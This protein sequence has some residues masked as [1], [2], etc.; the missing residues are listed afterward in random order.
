MAEESLSRIKFA[1]SDKVLNGKKHKLL[2]YI[3]PTIHDFTALN[4]LGGY[5]EFR[6]NIILPDITYTNQ[7]VIYENSYTKQDDVLLAIKNLLR[8]SRIEIL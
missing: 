7:L 3:N 5:K 6:C 8:A 2:V 4:T 1:W